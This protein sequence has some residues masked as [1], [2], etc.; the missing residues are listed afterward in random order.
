[1]IKYTFISKATFNEIIEHYIANLPIHEQR[2][3]LINLNFLNEIKEIL[4]NPNNKILSDKNTR[5]WTKRKFKLKKI[6]PGDYRVIVRINNNLCSG[7]PP[8]ILQSDNGKEF[9]AEVIKELFKM[10]PTVKIINRHSQ[11]PQSQ[12]LIERINNGILQQKLELFKKNIYNKEDISDTIKLLD[13]IENLDDDMTDD[14]QDLEQENNILLIFDSVLINITNQQITQYEILR[15]MDQKFG[16]IK[17]YYI[18]NELELLDAT[19][20]LELDNILSNKISIREA[21]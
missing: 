21:A 11:Y 8:T 16:I 9:C 3:T 6:T 17:V 14:L 19:S 5:N 20:F 4:L 13:N 2:K 15:N 1:M 18:T 7:S 10:W 12:G